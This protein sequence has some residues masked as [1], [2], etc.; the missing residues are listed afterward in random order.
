[1][2]VRAVVSLHLNIFPAREGSLSVRVPILT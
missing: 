1:M 2:F